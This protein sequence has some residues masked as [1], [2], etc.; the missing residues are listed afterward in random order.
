MFYL[1]K[2]KEYLVLKA[3]ADSAHIFYSTDVPYS[4]L[5]FG[6]SNANAL[7]VEENAKRFS[8]EDAHKYA[9]ELAYLATD[10]AL[11]FV[12]QV[13]RVRTA[14]NKAKKLLGVPNVD[15]VEVKD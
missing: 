13:G 5:N 1:N 7:Y 15:P 12:A 11:V 8:D 3:R 6:H 14:F 10:G 2:R 9:K 4:A